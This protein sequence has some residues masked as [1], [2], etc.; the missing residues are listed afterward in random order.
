LLSGWNGKRSRL[1][2]SELIAD[3]DELD[4]DGECMAWSYVARREAAPGDMRSMAECHR[5]GIV[6]LRDGVWEDVMALS[7]SLG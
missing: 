4:G 1:S 6:Y 2:P 7:T 5:F 3:D